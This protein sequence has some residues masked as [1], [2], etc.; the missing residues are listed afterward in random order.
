M[1]YSA[2]SVVNDIVAGARSLLTTSSW[3]LSPVTACV[4]GAFV[5][6]L[7]WLSLR[8]LHLVV[9]DPLIR[10]KRLISSILFGSPDADE[11]LESLSVRG[12]GKREGQKT[13]S[14]S[15]LSTSGNKKNKQ[16]DGKR[17]KETESSEEVS[18]K[19]SASERVGISLKALKQM[20][21]KEKKK[22]SQMKKKHHDSPLY[23]D[24]LLGHSDSVLGLSC[25]VDGSKG[26][27]MVTACADRT[28]RVYSLSNS[29]STCIGEYIIRGG[30][31][32][33]ACLDASNGMQVAYMTLGEHAITELHV[34]HLNSA[35]SSNTINVV[36]TVPKIFAPKT[37][38][39]PLRLVMHSSEDRVTCVAASQQPRITAF[40]IQRPFDNANMLGSCDTNSIVNN[41]VAVSGS[42]CAIATFSS[43]VPIYSIST[44]KKLT[45][46]N[47]HRKKVTS[48]AFSPDGTQVVTSSEDL[49]CRI[50]NINV[51]HELQESPKCLCTVGAPSSDPL[52]RM[53]W[54][55]NMIAA[56]C[57]SDIFIL[58]A[59]NG[60]VKH[61][62]LRAH[63][64]AIRC[65]TWMNDGFQ[66][67]STT[68]GNQLLAS[69]GDDDLVHIWSIPCL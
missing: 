63:K 20:S 9:I 18:T 3:E 12:K 64:G 62:I 15:K 66:Q 34:A 1:Y 8:I 32:D 42:L 44:M 22:N 68:K 26:F 48:V 24:T 58:D 59:T 17:K 47:G 16:Q 2:M 28:M 5:A 38:F 10:V 33:V 41:D 46:L 35:F 7:V 37:D 69:G 19:T 40:D 56:A 23:M 43:D 4:L 13:G 67:Q 11:S 55:G 36:D 6:S 39:N 60:Q 51:R 53:A 50:W 31:S 45:S 21:Q 61:S 27:Y 14:K 65:L 30:I 57:G 52:T 29:K 54:A 49:T 25:G